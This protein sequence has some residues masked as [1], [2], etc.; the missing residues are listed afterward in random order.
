L[1]NQ[2][3]PGARVAEGTRLKWVVGQPLP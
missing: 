2:L 3:E 1:I